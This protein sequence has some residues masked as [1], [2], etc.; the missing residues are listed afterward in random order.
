MAYIPQNLQ[1]ESVNHWFIH[2][3]KNP[4]R[5]IINQNHKRMQEHTKKPAIRHNKAGNYPELFPGGG[6]FCVVDTLIIRQLDLLG[7]SLRT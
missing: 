3:D 2:H 7:R 5:Q 6:L 4:S 1:D